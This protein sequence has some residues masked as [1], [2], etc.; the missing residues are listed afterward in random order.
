MTP[1]ARP[2]GSH[3]GM[4]E[5]E[6]KGVE[7]AGGVAVDRPVR[8]DP[9]T[10]EDAVVAVAEIEIFDLEPV[11]GKREVGRSEEPDWDRPGG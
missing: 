6:Q 11:G 3:S 8:T 1:V 2:A 7:G 5:A 4:Q 9:P 10:Q